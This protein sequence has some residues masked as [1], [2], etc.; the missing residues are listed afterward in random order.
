[1]NILVFFAHPDDETILCGGT[2]AL[3]A[4]AGAEV[5][6]LCA[7][8]GEGGELGEPPLCERAELGAVRAAELECAVEALGGA[9]LTFLDYVDPVVGEDGRLHPYTTDLDALATQLVEY[10]RRVQ[11]VAVI[12]H[13]SDGEYG[14]PAHWVTH[15]AARRMIAAAD[16]SAPLLY[17]FSASFPNH[18]RPRLAN[19]DDPAHLVLDVRPAFDQKVAAAYC[20]RTQNAL[21]VRRMSKRAGRQLSLPE[22]LMKLES[23]HRVHP[24]LSAGAPQD[25]LARLLSPWSQPLMQP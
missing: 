10:V 4:R 8:R 15:Q 13:G 12:T 23:L 3:L 9:S 16:A 21:F 25:A 18:P 20:H 22:V 14:H 7:T 2:L 5:H 17:S 6:Y 19:P 24:P 1:M 11:A